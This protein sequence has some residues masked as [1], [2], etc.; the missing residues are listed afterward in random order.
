MRTYLP[1][2]LLGCFACG[3]DD[4][5]N[6]G[7][8]DASTDSSGTID[9]SVDGPIAPAMITLS[10]TA[11][12][13]TVQGAQPVA[14]AVIAAY[15]NADEATPV[16]MTTTTASGAFTLMVPTGGVALDGFLK[17][18]KAGFVATYLYAPAPIA[19]DTAMLPIIMLTTG[20]YGTVYV[21][22]GVGEQANKGTIA[23]VVTDAANMPVA[24][25][26]VSSTPAAT[27]KYN[28]ANGLPSG[29]ATATAAD[30]VAYMMNAPLGPVTVTAAKAGSTFAAHAVKAFDGALTTTLIV[31]Q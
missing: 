12:S 6:T 27:Y 13:R 9:A 29:S 17:A 7:G 21:L 31:P 26:T 30:G 1:I 8:A 25:A 10:G 5:G 19:A 2:L 16:A 3:G 23:V 22:A 24:G 4:G 28:G 11:T 18:T 14:D 15:R 20:T